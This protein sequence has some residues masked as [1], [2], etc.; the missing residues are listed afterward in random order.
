MP[1]VSVYVFSSKS[2]TNIWAGFG[3]GTWAVA[4]GAEAT[5]KGK[6]TKALKMPIGSFGLLYCEPWK[7]FTLPFVTCSVPQ[8]GSFEEEIWAERWMLPF[9]FKA[10]GTPRKTMPGSEILELSGARERGLTNYANYLTVQGNFAFQASA[11][12]ANDWQTILSR[13]V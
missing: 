6:T 4:I 12:D 3:A 13:L 5:N 7:A 1:T 2:I 11:I 9:K 10:L 8:S